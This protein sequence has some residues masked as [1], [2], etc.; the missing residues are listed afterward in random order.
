MKEN[1]QEGGSTIPERAIEY[2]ISETKAKYQYWQKY[3]NIFEEKVKDINKSKGE[4]AKMM[5]ERPDSEEAKA[6]LLFAQYDYNMHRNDINS[7]LRQYLVYYRICRDLDITDQFTESQNTKSIKVVDDIENQTFFVDGENLEEV[8]KG[9]RKEFLDRI[10]NNPE[11]V[12]IAE[13]MAEMLSK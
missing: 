3:A 1:K 13:Q 7:L 9:G 5:M 12:K 11:L 2:L 10:E 6:A 8:V 4:V